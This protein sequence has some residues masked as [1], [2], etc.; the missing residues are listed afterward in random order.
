MVIGA[1]VMTVSVI[2]SF[3]LTVILV[4]PN[5][6]LF[7]FTSVSDVLPTTVMVF[8]VVL[9]VLYWLFPL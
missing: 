9:D 1:L 4:F 6:W 7:T 8:S 2:G 5:V 3:T